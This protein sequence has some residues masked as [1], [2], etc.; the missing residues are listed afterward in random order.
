MPKISLNYD[1]A[2]QFVEKNKANGFYW[3]N[4]TIV[5]FSPHSAA[6]MDKKGSYKNNK[7]GFANRYDVKENGTWDLSEKYA[8]FI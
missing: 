2:H 7:W 4:Y 5:K 6:Y 1:Q 8:K 3:D